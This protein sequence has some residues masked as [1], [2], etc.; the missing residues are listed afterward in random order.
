MVD[1]TFIRDDDMKK[2]GSTNM[3]T[4]DEAAASCFRDLGHTSNTKGAFKHSLNEL[5]YTPWHLIS[6]VVF[7]MSAQIYL[8]EK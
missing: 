4:P 5:M 1:T 8:K 7:K 2:Q 6:K 3:I